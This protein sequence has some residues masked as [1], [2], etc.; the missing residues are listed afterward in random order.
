MRKL[1]IQ[2]IK[3]V[4]ACMG[5][6]QVY[7]E[8]PVTGDLVING[9]LCRKLGELK[10]G[11]EKSFGIGEGTAKVFVI[12]DQLSRNFSND[13][14]Q[15][16]P[17]GGDVFLSGKNRFNP[18]AGNPFI[19]NNNRNARA[20]E[21]RRKTVHKGWILL[22]ASVLAGFLGGYLLISGIRCAVDN[23]EK[24][25]RYENMQMTLTNRFSEA[26]EENFD[27]CYSSADVAVLGLKEEFAQNPGLKDYDRSKYA[28]M[29]ID[30]NGLSAAVQ[31]EG[32][33]MWFTYGSA[34]SD[35]YCYTAYLYQTE[36][37]F[38]LIQFCTKAD[39]GEKQASNIEKWA[40]SVQFS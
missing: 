31:T 16:P 29:V 38:W 23:G 13:F 8:D 33:L 12:A 21:N 39:Q 14:Y 11:E 26:A 27:F 24:T 2:R 7:I 36:D 35:G 19:F 3:S 1:T 17:G 15:L 18:V 10:N 34:Q 5:R 28:Q 9:I 32:E 6:M 30:N 37:A 20:L 40:K 4:V 22:A 25:V